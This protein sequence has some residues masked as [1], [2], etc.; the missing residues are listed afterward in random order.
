VGSEILAKPIAILTELVVDVTVEVVSRLDDT[1]N[2]RCESLWEQEGRTG[3][4]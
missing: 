1:L 2:K 3:P 4:M